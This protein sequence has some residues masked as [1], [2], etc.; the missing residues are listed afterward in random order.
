MKPELNL[1]E[2][3]ESPLFNPVIILQIRTIINN[4]KAVMNKLCFDWVE[5]IFVSKNLRSFL[6]ALVKTETLVV[7]RRE[8]AQAIRHCWNEESPE[9][10]K[11]RFFVEKRM[12]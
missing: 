1:R 12:G 2:A 11:S 4:T 9:S 10:Q 7:K 5:E 6:P 8:I 3:S